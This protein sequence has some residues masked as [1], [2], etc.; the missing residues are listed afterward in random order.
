MATTRS[1]PRA[2]G[3]YP[4]PPNCLLCENLMEG[5]GREFCTIFGQWI[6]SPSIAAEDC[7]AFKEAE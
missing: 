2:I 1:G 4:E 5:G 7:P 6:L 3:K